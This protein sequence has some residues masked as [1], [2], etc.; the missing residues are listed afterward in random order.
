MAM[1]MPSAYSLAMSTTD[2]RRTVSVLGAHRAGSPCV[3]DQCARGA[4]RSVQQRHDPVQQA[5]RDLA[6]GEQ[7]QVVARPVGAED[8]DA[9]GVGAEARAG[10]GDVVGDEEVGALAAELVGGAVERAGLRREPD[11][12]RARVQRRA[13]RAPDLR[14]DVLGGLELERSGRRPG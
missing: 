12:D 14:E 4:S 7:R 1:R 6:L 2:R 5:V 9:V 11:D 8:H 13:A 3:S 10:L